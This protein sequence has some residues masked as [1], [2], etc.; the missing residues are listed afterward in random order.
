MVPFII[1]IIIIMWAVVFSV[2]LRRTH[3]GQIYSD[4]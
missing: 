4:G 2:E 3:Y 1:I